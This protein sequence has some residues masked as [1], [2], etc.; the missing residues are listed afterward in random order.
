MSVRKWINSHPK[1]I[2]CGTILS[3]LALAMVLMVVLPRMRARRRMIRR[4]RAR[5]SSSVVKGKLIFERVP[6]EVR[7]L[8]G[9]RH[10]LE[11][12]GETIK[13]GDSLDVMWFKSVV[14]SMK[15]KGIV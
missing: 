14:L 3:L 6:I 1:T 2:L 12:R 8:S 13:C 9:Y 15:K 7:E 5:R 10:P 11:G 4:P